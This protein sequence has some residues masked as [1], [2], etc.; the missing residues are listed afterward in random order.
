M[1]CVYFCYIYLKIHLEILYVN[2]IIC[3]PQEMILLSSN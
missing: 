1:Q 3:R 2:F